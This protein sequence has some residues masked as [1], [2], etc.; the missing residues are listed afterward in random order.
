MTALD[1]K[2]P[3]VDCE[4]KT[5]KTL[6]SLFP[7]IDLGYITYENNKSLFAQT[8]NY[9]YLINKSDNVVIVYDKN[10]T[11]RDKIVFIFMDNHLVDTIK[12]RRL[13]VCDN[14]S[15]DPDVIEQE[16]QKMFVEFL[17]EIYK[18]SCHIHLGQNVNSQIQ[19]FMKSV[20]FFEVSLHFLNEYGANVLSYISIEDKVYNFIYYAIVRDGLVYFTMMFNE[21]PKNQIFVQENF[22]LNSYQHYESSSG[23]IIDTFFGENFFG[24]VHYDPYFKKYTLNLK[25]LDAANFSV[26]ECHQVLEHHTEYDVNFIFDFVYNNIIINDPRYNFIQKLIDMS[27]LQDNETLNKE[28]MKLYEMALI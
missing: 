27:I 10:V 22:K 3:I 28:H 21:D 8:D 1:H 17:E 4:D 9:C 11:G 16:R 18:H 5:N 7:D 15:Y 23:Y 20:E 25:Y 24:E 26:I 14:I 13:F 12:S 19:E 2:L 6:S